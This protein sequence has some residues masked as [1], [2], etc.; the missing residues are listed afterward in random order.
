MATKTPMTAQELHVLPDNGLRLELVRGELRE[1]A[2]A[3]AEHG[4]I[5]IRAAV[6]LVGWVEPRGLGEEVLN[7]DTGFLIRRDPDTVRLPDVSFLRKERWDAL[8][9]PEAFVDGPPDLAIEI[10]SPSDSPGEVQEKVLEWL[11]A[12]VRLLWVVRP[13]G[14]MATVHSPNRRARVLGVDDT[15]DGGDVL[16]GFSLPVRALFE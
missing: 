6:R 14:R 7:A 16:P 9:R 1:M 10:V 3:G 12:G 15:L 8:E 13:R 5:G 2:A 11:A 4:R